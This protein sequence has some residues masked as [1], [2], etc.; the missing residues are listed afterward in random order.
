MRISRRTIDEVRQAADVVEA[1]SEFT[2][3]RRQGARFV[4]LCPYPDHQE[5]TPSFSVSPDLGLYYCF[6]CQRGG[7]AIK[8]VQDLRSTTFAEAVQY[9]A[10]KNGLRIEYESSSP[11]EAERAR[12]A[13]SRRRRIYR[14][15]AAAAV[16]YHKFLTHS[17]AAE[18]ARRYLAERGISQSTMGEFRLGYAPEGGREAFVR[19]MRKVRVGEEEL[20]LAGLLSRRGR[21]RFAGRITFPISDRR[22]RVVGF[23]ARVVGE[24]MPK[25]LNT[26][27]TEVFNKRNLL[28]GLPQAAGAMRRERSAVVVEGYTD[29][30]MLHQGGVENVVATLGTAM[31]E[32]HLRTLSAHADTIY[33]LF[34]PDAAGEKAVE[35]VTAAAARFRLDVRVMKLEEDPADWVLSHPASELSSMLSGAVPVME[36]GIRRIAGRYM[37]ADAASRSR[38]LPEV[39]A[40]IRGLHDPVLR[41]EAVR[42]ASEALGVP[43]RLLQERSVGDVPV[44]GY[45][46][47]SPDDPHLQAGREVLAL[48]LTRPDLTGPLLRQG[49]DSPVLPEP[50]FLRQ[51]DFSDREQAE[52]FS[53]LGDHAG[54]SLDGVLTDERLRSRM[55]AVGELASYGER[56]YPTR[57]SVRE[58]WLRLGV[59]SCRRRKRET[60]DY[61]L[62]AKL[63]ARARL[64]ERAMRDVPAVP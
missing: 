47:P 25:Y 56:L 63:H 41:R 35:R 51:E 18:G 32:A 53:I 22:G 52:I 40:M 31:T 43:A 46:R 24:G 64:L 54:E 27:E 29:V 8:L 48:M 42:I 2:A 1:A 26:P 23:G 10:E 45:D 28:Y 62:K 33:L 59:L 55:D 13:E 58:A 60:T 17:R 12:R 30:L 37:G 50:F 5:K 36:Y 15:L 16:Y 6:G 61:D 19:A 14:A 57:E 9:L 20:G 49:V 11:E 39:R 34:D 3:L 44:R 21:E 7:D 38:A 4:G